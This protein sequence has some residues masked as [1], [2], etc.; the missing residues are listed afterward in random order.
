[1]RWYNNTDEVQPIQPIGFGSGL[2]QPTSSPSILPTSAS[3]SVQPSQSSRGLNK[4]SLNQIL[5]TGAVVAG[6]IS[7]Q[8]EASGAA[9]KRK[10]RIEACGRKGLGYL[11]SRR[12]KEEYR[13]CIEAANAASY[14]DSSNKSNAPSPA[15]PAAEQKSN[16][17]I[18]IG[19]GIVIALGATAYFFMRKK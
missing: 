8:R 6:T 12:K 14:S 9:A 19:V 17:N 13:K 10:A 7:S 15:P 18:I 16:T 4:D 11:L 3:Q 1:M 5:T 2:A